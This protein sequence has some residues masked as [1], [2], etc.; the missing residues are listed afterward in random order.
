MDPVFIQ[1]TREGYKNGMKRAE[2]GSAYRE[3]ITNLPLFRT[4]EHIIDERTV[5]V[6]ATWANEVEKGFVVG[7]IVFF[8]RQFFFMNEIV[9]GRTQNHQ[10]PHDRY[11]FSS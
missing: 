8:I 10:A 4:A 5:Q 6:F 11:G 3:R 1:G 9:T 7:D 2:P